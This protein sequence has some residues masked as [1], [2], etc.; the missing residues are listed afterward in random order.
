LQ[1]YF[2]VA[3]SQFHDWARVVFSIQDGSFAEGAKSLKFCSER[4]TSGTGR[5]T[6]ALV[7]QVVGKLFFFR[8]LLIAQCPLQAVFE[9]VKEVCEAWWH[10]QW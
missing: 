7:D 6:R 8:A 3:L 5:K 9:V 1:P 4:F 10:I 2:C